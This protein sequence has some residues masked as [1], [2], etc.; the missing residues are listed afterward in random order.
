MYPDKLRDRVEMVFEV[1][2]R[3]TQNKGD[4]LGTG[5]L[6]INLEALRAWIKCGEID[7]GS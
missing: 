7:S 1:R 4:R 6:R 5:Q 3:T 2:D